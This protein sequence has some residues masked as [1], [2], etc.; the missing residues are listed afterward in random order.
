MST[1]AMRMGEWYVVASLLSRLDI[2]LHLYSMNGI[3]CIAT[4]DGPFFCAAQVH[5][6]RS[7]YDDCT[8]TIFLIFFS[9][10]I[11]ISIRVLWILGWSLA[12]N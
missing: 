3:V 2:Y 8:W 9:I 1:L 7:P 10:S 6:T 11:S 4:I 5:D 12:A